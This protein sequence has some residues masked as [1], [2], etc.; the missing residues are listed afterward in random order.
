MVLLI[1]STVIQLIEVSLVLLE[2]IVGIVRQGSYR[3]C[4]AC[5]KSKEIE[6]T[7]V[8]LVIRSNYGKIG[9]ITKKA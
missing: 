2:V 5:I 7:E 9:L 1:T 8:T 3:L 4:E 6:E